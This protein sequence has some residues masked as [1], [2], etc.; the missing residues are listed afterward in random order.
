MVIERNNM[1]Y[2]SLLECNAQNIKVNAEVLSINLVPTGLHDFLTSVASGKNVKLVPTF[3]FGTTSWEVVF[4]FCNWS[5][6]E[7]VRFIINE[8]NFI[9]SF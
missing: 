4:D 3:K 2:V 5:S 8:L 1:G 6:V 7:V 9:L